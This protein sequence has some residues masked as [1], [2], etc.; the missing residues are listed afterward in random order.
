MVVSRI[1]AGVGLG[2]RIPHIQRV[3]AERPAV[4]WWEVHICN[5]INSGLGWALLEGVAEYYPLSFHGVSL[6]LGGVDDLD[7]HY[8]SQL[9]YAVNAFN[10]GLISEHIAF[11]RLGDEYF[12]D[13][14]P[15]PYTRSV[16]RHI[17]NRIERVQE[18]LGRQILI[19]N[20]SRYAGYDQDEMSEAAFLSEVCDLA[21]CSLL[22]DLNNAYVN[23][24]NLNEPVENFLKH[25]PQARIKEIHLA[26]HSQQG[27]QVI[28]TH[29]CKVSEA[30]WEIFATY[31]CV[32][33]ETPCLIEWDNQIPD[34]NTLLEEK[35]R[36]Q[37]ILE[38]YKKL[39]A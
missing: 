12:H 28:D 17:A 35:K 4:D 34:L 13:L 21:D 19:E 14:L 2:L 32:H 22:L 23:E 18:T 8:L 20:P 37:D 39:L 25:L 16:A 27:T 15:V 24:L 11:T 26:G 9:K 10:P 36:A 3:L 6:N 1:C 5:Y 33:P 7:K 30:V 29:S 31:S 38:K